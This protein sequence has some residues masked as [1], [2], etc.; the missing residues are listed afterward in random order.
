MSLRRITLSS[1]LAIALLGCSHPTAPVAA[2]KPVIPKS[3]A[4]CVA[5]GGSWTT[6]GLPMPDKP[7][8]CD[9][10][11]ADAGKECNDSTQCQGACLAPAGVAAG[12]RATGTCSVYLA[13]FGN[14][15]LITNGKVESV[16]VE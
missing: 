5:H 13:N 9:L 7:K 6:L 12:S 2:T 8:V 4:E 1:S 16:N 15:S 11:T 3:E 14:V 10:K